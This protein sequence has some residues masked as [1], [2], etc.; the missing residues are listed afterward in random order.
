MRQARR[1]AVVLRLSYA[2][3]MEARDRKVS[4]RSGRS[5]P[6]QLP[7]LHPMR[8]IRV[9]SLP[10]LEFLDVRL[11]VAFDLGEFAV[12]LGPWQAGSRSQ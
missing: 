4:D 11:V 8:L 2:G 1:R 3:R 7:I 9:R 6:H 12:L 5:A 10:P